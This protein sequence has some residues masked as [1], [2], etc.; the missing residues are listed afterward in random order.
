MGP[1]AE[2]QSVEE[3]GEEKFITSVCMWTSD[4]DSEYIIMKSGQAKISLPQMSINTISFTG[5][6]SSPPHEPPEQ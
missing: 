3:P 1:R 2:C 4:S 5:Q 6:A